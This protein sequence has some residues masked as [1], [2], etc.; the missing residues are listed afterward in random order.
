[1]SLSSVSSA[2][3]CLVCGRLGGDER[4][5]SP[6]GVHQHGGGETRGGT[7]G[8]GLNLP[9]EGRPFFWA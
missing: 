7:Q 1:M 9:G 3:P 2:G 4:D 8:G 5:L 6:H